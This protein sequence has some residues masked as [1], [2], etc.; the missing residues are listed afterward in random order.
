MRPHCIDCLHWHPE[1]DNKWGSC[2]MKV[3]KNRTYHDRDGYIRKIKTS[4]YSYRSD[5]CWKWE[6]RDGISIVISDRDT[7]SASVDMVLE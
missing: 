1:E 2:D 6:Y 7:Y 4:I 5:S 3:S